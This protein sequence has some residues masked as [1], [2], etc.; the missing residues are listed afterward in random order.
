MLPY[1]F[2]ATLMLALPLF[3][4]DAPKPDLKIEPMAG[5]STLIIKNGYSKPLNA[6][7]IELVDYPGSNY[8]STYDLLGPDAIPA[9][10]EKKINVTNM[11]IGAVP[12]HVKLEAAIYEDGTTVGAPEKVKHILDIRRARLQNTR[13]IVQR[14][15]KD[16]KDGKDKD[17]VVAD[18]REWAITIVPAP[19]YGTRPITDPAKTVMRNMVAVAAGNIAK[20]S[21]DDELGTLKKTEASL[22]ASKP[23]LQ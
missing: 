14:I 6:F 1:R 17:A 22:A 18:L 2:A 23:V 21:V 19:P 9:G 10:A 16:K 20:Q 7:L 15:E 4:A 13:E 8:S 12:E 5:G 11:T 3:A